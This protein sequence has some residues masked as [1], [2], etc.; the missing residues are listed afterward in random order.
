MND[1]TTNSARR[2]GQWILAAIGTLIIGLAG[3]WLNDKFGP[4]PDPDPCETYVPSKD[5]EE[6]L[7]QAKA[8]SRAP[9]YIHEEIHNAALQGDFLR[10]VV[11]CGKVEGIYEREFKDSIIRVTPYAVYTDS[12]GKECRELSVSKKRDGRW[13]GSS[14]IYCKTGGKWEFVSTSN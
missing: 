10:W 6:M 11:N 5:I 8:D 13:Q 3:V 1:Q 12:D 4:D 2:L 7:N 14:D 9:D